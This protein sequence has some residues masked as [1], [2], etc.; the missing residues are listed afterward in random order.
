MDN[1]LLLKRINRTL[2]ERIMRAQF[3]VASP[4][5]LTMWRV[6]DEEGGVV[7][8]PVAPGEDAQFQPISAGQ[9]WGKPWQTVWFDVRGTIPTDVP[10]G[11]TVEARINL[12]FP[13]HS[14]GFLA[15]GLVRGEDGVAI[16]AIN[17]RNQW[18]PLPQE[19]GATFHLTIEAAANPLL[20]D[21]LPFQ[22]TLDGDKLTA[23][24][25][26]MYVLEQADVVVRHTEVAELILDIQVLTEMIEAKG[27]PFGH[28]DLEVLYALNDALDQLDLHNIPGT[29][30]AARDVLKPIMERPAL[31]GAHR[32]SAVGHAHIDSAWL[33][34]IRETK[35]KVNRTLANV[36][37]LIEDGTGLV[38]ALP[39]A[40]HVAWLAEEDPE[41]FERVKKHVAEGSIVPVGA[42]WV[43]PDAVLP[44]GEALARQIVEGASFFEEAFGIECKEI[45]LP[46]S[47]GYS[48]AIPQLAREAGITRFLTQKISWNQTNVFPHHTLLWEGLDGSRI[49][50]HFPPADTYGSEVTG[51]QV[52]HAVNN[53]KDKGR[54][55]V[56]LLP[57][58]YG[59]GGGGP[60]RD[61]MARIQRM[62]DLR[63][64]PRVVAESPH[65]FFDRAEADLPDPAVWVGELYLELHRGTFTSQIA[66]KQGNRRSEA[67]LR[68]T[69]LWCTL[70]ALAGADY[71]YDELRK[72]WHNVLLCQFH[73]I[74]PGTSVAWVYR[75]VAAIYADVR[76][77]CERLIEGALTL[78]AT[79]RPA[80]A[81]FANATSFSSSGV[82]PF[83]AAAGAESSEPA[84]VQGS[85]ISNGV[86]TLE[87]NDDGTCAQIS[88][89]T[90]TYIP[91][92]QR[93]GVF[94]IFQDFPNMWDAWDIDSFY[95]G[96]REDLELVSDGVGVEGETAY[97]RAHATFGASS[98][99]IEWTLAPGRPYVDVKAEVD[100]HE[101]EKLLK[102][103]FP[104][105]IHTDHAQYE[106]QMGYISRPTHTNT[107]WEEAKFE[108]SAHRWVRLA[109]A[110]AAWSIANDATYGW[111]ITRHGA[112]RRGTWSDVRA[113]LV[114][115]AIYPDPNQDQGR[116]TW[117]F[118]IHPGAQVLDA[119]ADGQQ[120][121]LPLR[122]A[123]ATIGAP[124]ACTGAVIESVSM[125]PDR[126]GDV[127]LRLYEATGA[128]STVTLTWPDVSVSATDLRYRPSSEA[129]AV[130][131]VGDDHTLD[132]APF[133][134]AT[135]RV[136]PR[137]AP[138]AKET[139]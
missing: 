80:A 68:E 40:Q 75:E 65:A 74:L 83:E 45:W 55:N 97:A 11:D 135:L 126:S 117:T 106:T 99:N 22:E 85:R 19:P 137:T 70:A 63:G 12:G 101:H 98:M 33:W 107:S 62:S 77:T 84:R 123:P 4:L 49:F 25:E 81:S 36:C 139:R 28:D 41:L 86:L 18:I 119:V 1:S 38:F 87:F 24:R 124:F 5:Q 53:F 6:P 44:G 47:F 34:P 89:A 128:P 120:L 94:S 32:L 2:S 48:A 51:A 43:E 96:T 113:T 67:L 58:G 125:A 108:V 129:P 88:D 46:D 121:N 16:K 10:D 105:D 132:L 114:K 93:A 50:T 21:V 57:F 115:S 42:M 102:L 35:R 73:D 133:Q 64:A 20:L 109:N 91:A 138:T 82:A 90:R 54:T 78:L 31:P 131:T 71:P 95:K 9:P 118:R 14:V 116:F 122:P 17:P 37:R 76:A 3:S 8:E 66:A 127:V 111:D 136:R 79:G 112:G 29:A 30:A 23:S 56:S 39:A 130:T 26:D 61:M 104:V 69:E 59:D 13:D 72:V 103:S 100:W 52:A 27:E 92:G 60:T 134:I 110:G 15:E 7:G